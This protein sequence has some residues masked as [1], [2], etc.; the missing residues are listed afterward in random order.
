VRLSAL[1][2]AVLLI[3]G[4]AVPIAAADELQD[5]YQRLKDAH[6]KNDAPAVKKAA[7]EAHG[8]ACDVLS[9][10]EPAAGAEKETWAGRI[11]YAKSVDEF[12]EY[13]LYAVA[14]SQ[15][16]ATLVDLI[17]TLE[18]QNPKSKYLDDAYGVYI[19]ALTKSSGA[20]KTTAVAEKALSHFPENEDLLLYLLTTAS[21][22]QQNDRALNFANRLVAVVNKHQKPATA[23]AADWERKR[24]YALM[25]GYWT[26]GV[27]SAEKGQ[28][29]NADRNLRAALPLVRG[30]NDMLAPALFHLGVV[31]YQ[32]YKMTMNRS[33]L[34]EAAQFS[35]QAATIE[36]PYF[37][38]ARRNALIMRNEA[39]SRR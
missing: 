18:Q 39:A 22:H 15:Q 2:L 13:A 16:P 21:T 6:A 3:L 19:V 1:N 25:R 35:E 8:L 14:I 10:P 34:L 31:N 32:L 23:A 30:N 7:A 12:A 29:L 37:E 11:E 24:N 5:A 20:P 38:Q 26:A 33:K 36:G 9:S 17:S 27:I 4:P 28:Y